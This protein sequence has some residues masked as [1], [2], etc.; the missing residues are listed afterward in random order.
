MKAPANWIEDRNPFK[1]A[2]PPQWW[3]QRLHDVDPQLRVMPSLTNYCYVVGRWSANARRFRFLTK[4]T[5]FAATDNKSEAQRLLQHG[6]IFIKTLTTFDVEHDAFF[7]W[8]ARADSW[9]PLNQTAPSKENAIDKFIDGVEAAE[10]EADKKRD[11]AMADE[12]M[13]RGASAYTALLLRRGNMTFVQ[14][15][16]GEVNQ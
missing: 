11:A 1:L 6:C 3:L 16:H 7:G 14:G 2:A 12:A 13:Q 8:L 9:N 15:A 5:R 4:V 10:D